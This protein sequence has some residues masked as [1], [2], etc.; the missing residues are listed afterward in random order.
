METSKPAGHQ[1]EQ[2]VQV[3]ED[4]EQ[5][6]KRRDTEGRHGRSEEK[7]A[8]FMRG[9]T[10]KTAREYALQPVKVVPDRVRALHYME[11]VDK[12][13]QCLLI[14]DE[15]VFMKIKRD[16]NFTH[17]DLDHYQ[18]TLSKCGTTIP[19]TQSVI[20]LSSTYPHT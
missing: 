8:V 18:K 9:R 17:R 13:G 4:G 20:H 12:K 14:Y 3:L 5:P 1:V 2:G 16:I 6:Y 15:A 7:R 19:T 11:I 10:G